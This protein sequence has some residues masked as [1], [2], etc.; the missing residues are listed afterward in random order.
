MPTDPVADQ[1]EAL[2][3]LQSSILGVAEALGS[4]LMQTLEAIG[5]WWRSELIPWAEQAGLAE[6][7]ILADPATAAARMIA[8]YAPCP[9]TPSTSSLRTTS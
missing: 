3:T 9:P 6:D 5:T 1:R 7:D 2:E 8:F 4:H